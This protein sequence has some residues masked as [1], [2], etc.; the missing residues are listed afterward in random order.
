[1]RNRNDWCVESIRGRKRLVCRSHWGRDDRACRIQECY[2]GTAVGESVGVPV[3]ARVRGPWYQCA[4]AGGG[5][6]DGGR[7]DGADGADGAARLLQPLGPGTQGRWWE[8]L[9]QLVGMGPVV[10]V[11]PVLEV[12]VPPSCTVA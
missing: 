9:K 1:V 6:G 10:P 7:G 12:L 8:V 5:V 4:K 3:G 2:W 11:V